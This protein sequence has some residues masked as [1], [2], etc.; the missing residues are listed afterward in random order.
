MLHPCF[1]C[2]EVG[3]KSLRWYDETLFKA[4]ERLFKAFEY[5]FKAYKHMFKGFEQR[6]VQD[7]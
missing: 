1:F 6:I 2:P 4:Y 7:G 5:M 3:K